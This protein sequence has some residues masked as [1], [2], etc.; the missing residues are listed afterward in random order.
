MFGKLRTKHLVLILLG[1]AGLWWLSGL[2]SP[3]ARARTFRDTLFTLDTNA[4]NAFTI[5]P[6]SGKGLPPL[7][8]T[9]T[10]DG[11]RMRWGNDSGAVDPHPVHELLRSWSHLRVVRL[12]GRVS[13]IAAKYD[14][15]DSTADRLTIIS[16]TTTQELRVGRQTAGE[17]PM[18]LVA[19]PDDE[20][21]YAV[22]GSMGS[23]TDFTFS[24]WLPKYLVTGD[25]RNWT[26]LMFNFPADSGYVMERSSGAWRIDGVELDS[27]RTG[28]F[29]RSLARARGRSVTDPS[30]TLN[31]VPQFRLVVE[32]TTRAEPIVVVV[33]VGN[34]KFIVRSTLNPGTVMPFDGREEVPRMFR[35]RTAFMPH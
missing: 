18:T 25:P 14:L 30:D 32:D 17:P 22:E 15:D 8:F 3:S 5:T 23:Y 34:N 11:W 19:L 24:E 16:G 20:N 13:E 1:L 7:R 2:I 27:A 26:R 29:L 33:F 35:P 9:R 4:I 6:A 31:A 10:A 12:A 21:A 28:K